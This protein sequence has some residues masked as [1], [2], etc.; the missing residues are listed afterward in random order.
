MQALVFQSLLFLR[1]KKHGL[2]LSSSAPSEVATLELC[3]CVSACSA[4]HAPLQPF[5]PLLKMHTHLNTHMSLSPFLSVCLCFHLVEDGLGGG[6]REERWRWWWGVV[7]LKITIRIYG[8]FCVLL[9]GNTTSGVF[10]VNKK[11]V[12]LAWCIRGKSLICFKS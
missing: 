1:V 8:F 3:S 2:R 11:W 7:R 9:L 12:T 4:L 6:K 5:H 10:T